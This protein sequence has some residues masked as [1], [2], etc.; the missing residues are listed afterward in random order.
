MSSQD[1]VPQNEKKEIQTTQESSLAEI[2]KAV[3]EVR[4]PMVMA[5]EFPRDE[6]LS[7]SRMVT[8]AKRH[9]IAEKAFYSY[10][11]GKGSDSKKVVG[12]TIRLIEVIKQSW[13]N[14][15]SGFKILSRNDEGAYVYCFCHDYES[16]NVTS[17]QIFVPFKIK[18]Y[19]EIKTVSDPRDQTELIAN[20][21]MRNVRECIKA[22]IPKDVIEKVEAQCRLTI[23]HGVATGTK[24]EP[25][26]DRVR[27]IVGK[28]ENL[29]VS[30]EMLEKRLG[31]TIELVIE[32]E[33]FDLQSIF[34]A[35]D[36]TEARREDY[37]DF[38]PKERSGV[39]SSLNEAI[40]VTKEEPK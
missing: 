19:G 8:A 38:G 3:E 33:I 32:E 13:G 11:K 2:R 9:S 1:M 18:A 23:S 14:L 12:P 24:P 37:F 39:K 20:H 22:E 21:A 25:T 16:N 10:P 35:L 34:N 36:S 28:F 27:R 4:A 40:N 7:I 5:R 31:H 15:N 6:T 26:I 17:R 30:K 29:G